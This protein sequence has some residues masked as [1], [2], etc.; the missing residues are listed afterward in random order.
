MVPKTQLLNAFR[1]QKFFPFLVM[2]VLLPQSMLESIQFNRKL[3]GR[4]I[5][6]E[7]VIPR[8]MLTT[9]FESSK[10]PRPQGTPQFL[11]LVC[12]LVTEAAGI[13]GGIHRRSVN[14]I[15]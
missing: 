13:A 1:R 4:T 11:F 3:C 2:P 10:T 12:L 6:V 15:F 14:D 5:E 9:K 7:I 8:R